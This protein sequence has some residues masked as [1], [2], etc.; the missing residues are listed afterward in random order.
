MNDTQVIKL[1]AGGEY[2]FDVVE[3]KAGWVGIA[4]RD[5]KV[6]TIQMPAP[7]KDEAVARLRAGIDGDLV[8]SNHG[9]ESLARQLADYFAGKKT[10]FTF[11]PDLDSL[12][13]FQQRVLRVTMTV[14]WGSVVSYRWI[15][16]KAGSPL[17]FRAAGQA[18]GQN[19]IPIAIPCHRVVASGGK[20]GGYSGGLHWKVQLLELEGVRL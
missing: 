3:T 12:T 4:G 8:E 15:A 9:F 2:V 19:P 13:D 20:L 10:Q 18:L 1:R 14:P 5:G 17:A 16:E 7:T 11:E 6:S